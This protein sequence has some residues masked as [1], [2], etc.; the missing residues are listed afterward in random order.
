MTKKCSLGTW[1]SFHLFVINLFVYRN[2]SRRNFGFTPFSRFLSL[3]QACQPVRHCG[4][5]SI[6]HTR[7]VHACQQGRTSH[8]FRPPAQTPGGTNRVPACSGFCRPSR[9]GKRAAHALPSV[10]APSIARW[11]HRPNAVGR[12]ATSTPS[13][14]ARPRRLPTLPSSRASHRRAG[15]IQFSRRPASFSGAFG[16]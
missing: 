12:G 3:A 14:Q 7:S 10:L 1:A 15:T 16:G 6:Q 4:E 5:F 2:E 8:G 13:S 9:S 11:P